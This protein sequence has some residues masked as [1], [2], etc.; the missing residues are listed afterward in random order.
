MDIQRKPDREGQRQLIAAAGVVLAS[1]AVALSVV[2]FRSSHRGVAA[3]LALLALVF[4]IGGIAAQPTDGVGPVK[5][6]KS[7]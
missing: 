4:L 5:V 2:A 6:S 3:A 1:I 7:T